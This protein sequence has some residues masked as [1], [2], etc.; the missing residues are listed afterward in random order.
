REGTPAEVS[1]YVRGSLSHLLGWPMEKWQ[2]LADAGNPEARRISASQDVIL[3]CRQNGYASVLHRI[4]GDAGMPMGAREM[5]VCALLEVRMDGPDASCDLGEPNP[6]MVARHVLDKG[7]A[8]VP[9]VD[10][11]DACREL[12]RRA[13][14]RQRIELSWGKKPPVAPN[15]ERLRAQLLRQYKK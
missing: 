1:E 11:S 7:F 5:A 9:C 3:Y 4:A 13:G 6:R 12:V 2:I 8:P 14:M 15:T 10:A